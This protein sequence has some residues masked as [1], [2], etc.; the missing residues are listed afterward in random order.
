MSNWD[1][2]GYYIGNNYKERMIGSQRKR[3]RNN[4][5]WVKA[6]RP[7][8]PQRR[9]YISAHRSKLNFRSGGYLGIENKFYDS[10][11]AASALTA[12]ANASGGE[13]DPSA[14]ILL[15]TVVQGDGQSNR[16]GRKIVMKQIMIRG[17]VQ[18]AP[19]INQTIVPQAATCFIALVLDTQTN[20]A[21]ITSEQV[22]TNKGATALLATS[23]FN[24]MERTGRFKVLKRLVFPL[25]QQTVAWDGTNLEVGGYSR[26][27]QMMVPLKNIP[28]LYSSTTETVANIVDNSLHIIAYV[29]N[30]DSVPKLSYNA[31]LRFVG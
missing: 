25:V 28:V 11:L 22:F 23:L 10:S 19:I 16:D 20:G 5:G 31:R 13:H 24:A 1:S 8:R 4:G 2:K 18:C 14:T 9:Q 15:N 17:V 3:K 12:P 27:F 7:M 26:P 30:T 21:T 6:T 29:S